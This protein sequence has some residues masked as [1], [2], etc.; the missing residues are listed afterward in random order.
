MDI[1]NCI[2]IKLIIIV[3]EK[4]IKLKTCFNISISLFMDMNNITYIF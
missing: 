3:Y 2:L 4:Y 1:V